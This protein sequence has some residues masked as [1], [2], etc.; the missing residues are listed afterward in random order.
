[1]PEHPTLLLTG[2]TG[3]IGGGLLD[4]LQIVNPHRRIVW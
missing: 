1:M 3:L 4:R 2:V